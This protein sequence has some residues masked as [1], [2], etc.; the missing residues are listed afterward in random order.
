MTRS[1]G[2]GKPQPLTQSKNVQYPWSFAA[3]GR[4]MGLLEQNPKTSYDL[5]T[6]P[7]E[8][9]GVSLQAGK[10]EAFLQTAADERALSSLSGRTVAGLFFR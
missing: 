6:V 7:I 10:P 4:R 9:D 5:L 8:S 1:D 2:G 3:N